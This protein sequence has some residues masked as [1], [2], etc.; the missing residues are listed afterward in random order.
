MLCICFG[1]FTKEHL[2]GAPFRVCCLVAQLLMSFA[3]GVRKRR[4]THLLCL[5]LNHAPCYIMTLLMSY[6]MY[7]LADHAE[8]CSAPVTRQHRTAEMIEDGT[9]VHLA[10]NTK[11]IKV[12]VATMSQQLQ[13]FAHNNKT[14]EVRE[15]SRFQPLERPK[16]EAGRPAKIG[17]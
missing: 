4:A 5:L 13:Q 1:F 14:F 2:T 17:I 12:R 7:I 9:L 11:R 3:R 16:H 10:H 6:I 15:H 8:P